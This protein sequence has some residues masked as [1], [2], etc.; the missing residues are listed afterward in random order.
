VLDGRSLGWVESFEQQVG[1]DLA[2]GSVI[3]NVVPSAS[4]VVTR[5]RLPP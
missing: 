5:S 3:R 4:S 2:T 1:H